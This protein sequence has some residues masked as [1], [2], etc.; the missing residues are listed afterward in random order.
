MID[1]V[2]AAQW[3]RDARVALMRHLGKNEEAARDA[4][5]ILALLA[6]RE[7]RERYISRSVAP[8]TVLEQEQ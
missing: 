6:D 8:S 1:N 4:S 2:Q 3:D 5:I 7:E